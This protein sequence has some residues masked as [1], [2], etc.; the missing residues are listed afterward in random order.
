MAVVVVVALPPLVIA[1]ATPAAIAAVNHNRL[2][3]KIRAAVARVA[4]LHDFTP[5][6]VAARAAAAAVGKECTD[7][8]CSRNDA[9]AHV[10]ADSFNSLKIGSS[11]TSCFHF[12]STPC[13]IMGTS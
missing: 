1:D 4:C 2:A 7:A 10:A 12:D 6:D 3:A 9:P 8:S 13:G 5:S 11:S